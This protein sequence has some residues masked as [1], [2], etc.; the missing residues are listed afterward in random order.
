MGRSPTPGCSAKFAIVKALHELEFDG[1]EV[2]LRGLCHVQMEPVVGQEH[3]HG[4]GDPSRGACLE[5]L[6]RRAYPR[7]HFEVVT[8]ILDSRN[9]GATG[10]GTHGRPTRR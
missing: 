4:R 1:E 5:A 8:M 9:R 7:I 2:F 3:R 6:A 10:G